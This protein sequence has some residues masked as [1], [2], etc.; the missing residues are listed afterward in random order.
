MFCLALALGGLVTASAAVAAD[1]SALKK[2]APERFGDTKN[3][4]PGV[5][6]VDA[7][8]PLKTGLSFAITAG[9]GYT[10]S[11]I[12][13]D[14]Q[15]HRF[16]GTVG[17]SYRPWSWLGLGVRLDGRYDLHTGGPTGNDTGLVGDPRFF[18]RTGFDLG[19]GF[20]LGG[21][22]LLWLPGS[23]SPPSISAD[24]ISGELSLL[25]S[26]SLQ[27]DMDIPLT[28][29]VNTGFRLDRSGNSI[30]NPDGLSPE[31][32]LALGVSDSNQI[33]VGV[34]AAYDLGSVELLAEWTWDILVGSQ[35]P[36]VQASP[37]RL[38]A[39]ARW[40][41]T[42]DGFLQGQLL[43]ETN[44]GARPIVA[45][46]EPLVPVEPRVSVIL[47]LNIRPN[48]L[49]DEPS[50]PA[51]V[52]LAAAEIKKEEPPPSIPMASLRGGV[53]GRE[54]KGLVG[55]LVR[56]TTGTVT[57]DVRTSTAGTFRLDGLP[58]VETKIVVEAEEYYPAE[59]TMQLVDGRQDIE[60]RMTPLPPLGQLRG[61]VRSLAGDPIQASISVSPGSLA[62]DVDDQGR[63]EMDLPPGRYDVEMKAA[64]Y[65]SQ[66]K[67]IRI[68][69]YGVTVLNV[70]LRAMKAGRGRR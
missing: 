11:V 45:V 15:H 30:E 21:Q 27:D 36:P 2:Q 18:V 23:D 8:G 24:A 60:I 34:G 51:P 37:L 66:K 10:E 26:Y 39:G 56:V 31:D 42:D 43:V 32:R 62:I 46:G 14:D 29:A 1:G 17:M 6:R 61:V 69:K 55:V 58:L 49:E 50:L 33:L 54:A 3:A 12:A 67:K 19:H 70:E 25:G 52:V 63:F 40:T 22:G 13:T 64:G 68:E 47:G 35:A 16:M 41:M 44:P 28:F 57:T 7:P 48:Y 5:I 65:G 4:M 38:S 59:K 20:S 53:S 9:Y